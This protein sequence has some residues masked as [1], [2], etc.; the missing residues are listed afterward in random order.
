M[1]DDARKTVARQ[2]AK[3]TGAQWTKRF[4]IRRLSLWE[5]S[6]RTEVRVLVLVD[7]LNENHRFKGW[8]RWLQPIDQRGLVGNLSRGDELLAPMVARHA[9]R[10]A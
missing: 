6:E 2:L 1:F 8:S 7:G 4:G 9:L 10:L 3:Q 5:R